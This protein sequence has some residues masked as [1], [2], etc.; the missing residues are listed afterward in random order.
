M[1]SEHVAPQ[2]LQR[3]KVS[4][5]IMFIVNLDVV[6]TNGTNRIVIVPKASGT[7]SNFDNDDMVSR[8]LAE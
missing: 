2:A 4:F 1:F 7:Y 8:T 6:T 3:A 5:M